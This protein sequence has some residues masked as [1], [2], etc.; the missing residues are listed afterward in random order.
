M[1]SKSTRELPAIHDKKHRK[2]LRRTRFAGEEIWKSELRWRDLLQTMNEGFMILDAETRFVYANEKFCRMMEYTLEEILGVPATEHIIE[3]GVDIF[4]REWSRRKEGVSETYECIVVTKNG[5]KRHVIVSPRPIFD[6]KGDFRFSYAVISDITERKQTMEALK[7]SEERLNLAIQ[8]SQGGLWEIH[9]DPDNSDR[10]HRIYISPQRKA[11]AGYKDEELPTTLSGIE[12]VIHGEDL[13]RVRKMLRDYYLG[14]SEHHDIEYRLRHKDGSLRCI[15]SRGQ[16]QRDERGR[17]A[18][19]IGMDWDFTERKRMEEALQKAHDDLEARVEARTRELYLAN[20]QLMTEIA[21]RRRIDEAL[22]LYIQRLQ[23][24]LETDRAILEARSQERIVQV[25]LQYVNELLRCPMGCVAI[26]DQRMAEATILAAVV[27]GVPAEVQ[28]HSTLPDLPALDAMCRGEVVVN[29]RVKAGGGQGAS[30]PFCPR[31]VGSRLT[32]PLVVHG[33]TIGV[34]SLGAEE[35]RSFDQE[36]IDIAREA[37]DSLAVAL[38]NARLLEEV[39]KHRRDL[40]RMSALIIEAQE[41]ERKRISIELHDEMGQALTA[42]SFNLAAIE[43]RLSVAAISGA[44]QIVA[45]TRSLADQVADHIH[46]LTLNLRPTMLDELGLFPTLRWYL[47]R[48][49][50]RTLIEVE[51]KCQVPPRVLS[52]EMETVL[53]RLIQEAL[54]NV[55]KHASASRVRIDLDLKDGWIAAS[56]QDNGVGFDVKA[57]RASESPERGV[58]LLGIQERVSFLGGRFEIRSAPGQGTNLKVEIPIPGD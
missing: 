48:W 4:L 43:T 12:N 30:Y 45:E 47:N 6:K 21:K 15:Y 37:A 20:E 18:R 34:L 14:R 56:I 32:V 1:P 7:E 9:I 39:V 40:Q 5:K 24:F 10:P 33:R 44:R 35:A 31:E 23:I 55:A 22:Q 52:E 29:N 11:L 38:H 50:Q 57:V 36:K 53:Y 46:D 26:F 27:D 42:I 58:G 3:A 54:N 28:E 51:F 8:G 16:L 25:A 19:I 41:A 17:P 13:P 2:G 49:T